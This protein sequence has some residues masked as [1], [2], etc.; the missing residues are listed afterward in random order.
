YRTF[1]DEGETFVPKFKKLLSAG[2]SQ[3]PE[4]L[5]KIVGLDVNKPDFW[6]LGM[7]QYEEFVDELEKLTN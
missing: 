4:E 1:K 5:G 6:Q 2:G 7:K 3:S